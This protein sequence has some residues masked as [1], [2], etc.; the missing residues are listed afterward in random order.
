[1]TQAAGWRNKEGLPTATIVPGVRQEFIGDVPSKPDER[2]TAIVT[3]HPSHGLDWLLDRWSGHIHPAVPNARLLVVSAILDKGRAGGEVP[4]EMKAI[5]AKTLASA[6]DGVEIVAPT[7]DGGM[8]DLYRK[9]RVHLYPGH[10]DDM[11]CWT[12]MESQA[13]GLPAVARPLGAIHER[14]HNGQTGQIAP[15]DTAFANVAI[16]LLTDDAMF[17]AM[18]RDAHLLQRE[19]SWDVVGA[20]FEA[21]FKTAA[22]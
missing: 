5:L 17:W 4:D 18:N 15:D 1:V 8:A 14:L 7:G 3:T 13:C 20:E 22:S 19:R 9:A 6:D 10:P 2:P 11:I 12:L 16:H 21:L